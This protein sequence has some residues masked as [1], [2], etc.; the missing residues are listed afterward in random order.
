MKTVFSD[1]SQVAHLWANQLQDSARN[2]GN[3]YFNGDAI[4]SYGSH[5]MIAKHHTNKKGKKVVLFTTRRY[6]NTTAKQIGVT[7]AACSHKELIYCAS[8][9]GVSHEINFTQWQSNM[10]YNAKALLTARKPEKYL[11]AI[12]YEFEQ[13]KVYADY[14]GLKLPKGLLLANS[15]TNKDEYLAFSAK[16]AAL[17]KKQ[18]KLRLA[19]I[20]K[21]NEVLLTKWLSGE[22][23]RLPRYD[24]ADY[25][26]YNTKRDRIQTS[27]N[28]EIPVMIAKTFYMY[29]QE[30]LLNG[31]C[32][33]CDNKLM[34]YEIRSIDKDFVRV[35]CHNVSMNEVNRLAAQLNWND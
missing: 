11:N 15:I 18:E 29:I 35:G 4:Y 31:G 14:F 24:G 34:D 33:E 12:S 3:Y 20:K 17:A 27:Q 1:I 5:F 22:S 8:P 13:A 23:N 10:E 19:I 2:S 6:S 30:V 28:V 32:T 25:L 7:Q 16:K 9:D 21:E 26:R